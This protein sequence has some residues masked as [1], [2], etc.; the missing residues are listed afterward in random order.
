MRG[1]W[2]FSAVPGLPESEIKATIKAAVA[3]AESV[4]GPFK[5]PAHDPRLNYSGARM[6]EILG[7]DGAMAD[8]LGLEQIIPPDLR[9]DRGTRDV[10]A[11]RGRGRASARQ[12]PRRELGVTGK[13]MG[14]ARH[15]EID[16]VHTRAEHSGHRSDRS[17]SATGGPRARRR[18]EAKLRMQREPDA[19][20]RSAKLPDAAENRV[21]E[22]DAGRAIG[23]HK[24]H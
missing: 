24:R 8:A 21:S 16:L 22:A 1:G 6:A 14:S 11:T 18:P 2:R 5:G 7:I 19:R 17:G 23:S 20:P 13:T 12:V 9:R 3:R 15:V 4:V 10:A